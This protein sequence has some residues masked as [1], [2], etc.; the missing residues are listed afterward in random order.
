MHVVTLTRGRMALPEI[1]GRVLF[2]GDRVRYDGLTHVFCRY[3]ER[4][5][6][7]QHDRVCVP[8][9]G[10]DFSRSLKHHFADDVLEASDIIEC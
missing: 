2:G 10:M 4:G 1:Y 3:L 9:D 8:T 7:G 6:V 5:I